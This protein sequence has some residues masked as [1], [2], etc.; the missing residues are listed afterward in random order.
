MPSA[1]AIAHGGVTIPAASLHVLRQALEE[2]GQDA[3]AVM[4]Q[5]GF[6]AGP[7]L[8][9]AFNAWLQAERGIDEASMLDRDHLDEALSSFFGQNGW[10]TLTVST[11]GGG[12]LTLDSPDWAEAIPNSTEWPSCLLSTGLLPAF[13]GALGGHTLGAMELECRSRGDRR[14]RFVVGA[15]DNLGTLYERLALGMKLE[16]A[17]KG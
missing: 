2:G 9:A 1:I 15:P 14:C 16:D 17:V 6:A 12:L 13:L 5:A 4:Q 7:A 8:L 10:G 11:L 3:A